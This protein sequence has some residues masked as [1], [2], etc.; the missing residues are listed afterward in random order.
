MVPQKK[1][2][3]KVSGFDALVCERCEKPFIP[4]Q[5]CPGCEFC[6]DLSVMIPHNGFRG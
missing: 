4:E 2:E 1:F 6:D 5:L 3:R